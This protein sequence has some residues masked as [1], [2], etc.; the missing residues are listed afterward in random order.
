MTKALFTYYKQG[1]QKLI[2][3]IGDDHPQ[4]AALR[5]LQQRLVEN[6]GALASADLS[7]TDRA[8]AHAD[9]L[10]ALNHLCLELTGKPFSVFCEVTD[11]T[12]LPSTT[13]QEPALSFAEYMHWLKSLVAQKKLQQT[14]TLG[15]IQERTL[16]ILKHSTPKEKGQVIQSL[17]NAGLICTDTPF[18]TLE[19]ADLKRAHLV[20]AEMDGVNLAGAHMQSANLVGALLREATLTRAILVGANLGWSVMRQS[21]LTEAELGGATLAGVD[22]RAAD[23]HGANLIMANLKRADLSQA[24]LSGANLLRANLEEAVLTAAD[25]TGAVLLWSNLARARLDGARLDQATYNQ[26]TIWPEEFDP[27]AAGAVIIA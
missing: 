9:I 22:L 10:E 25:L 7:A 8:T 1:L 2:A 23:V 11:A 26:Y 24:S 19:H 20:E 6:L 4:V 16:T 17:Y 12:P 15:M 5:I 14:A 21:C 13:A 3:A 18:I 27:T